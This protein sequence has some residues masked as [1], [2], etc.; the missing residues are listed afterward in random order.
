MFNLTGAFVGIA[1]C[2]NMST[3]FTAWI[4][5]EEVDGA[6]LGHYLR[7]LYRVEILLKALKES[8]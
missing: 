1:R 3:L 4:I 5:G 6:V 7:C 2:P 8:L